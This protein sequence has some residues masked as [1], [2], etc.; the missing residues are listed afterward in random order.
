MEQWQHPETIGYWIIALLA[1]VGLL[2]LFIVLLVRVT[3]RKIIEA[4]D[5][6]IE[7]QLRHHQL[8][9]ETSL[10]V[11]EKERTRIAADIHDELIGKLIRVQFTSSLSTVESDDLVSDC[12]STARRIS[13]DLIPP[14]IET[15]TMFEIVSG[16]VSPFRSE[17]HIDVFVVGGRNENLSKDAKV[18]ITRIIQEFFTNTRKHALAS[19][20][21][22]CLRF[23][24]RGIAFLMRDNGCGFDLN[25][26]VKGLG[27][28]N[29]ETRIYYLKGAVKWKSKHGV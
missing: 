4:K 26:K 22:I 28:R 24:N 16:I 13:H 6:E 2:S 1:V 20:L 11:Q 12:I 3:F 27:I 14:L 29:I 19:S 7:I 9:L 15:S 17:M 25:T 5:K 23:S 8:L 18:Q 10:L 21:E